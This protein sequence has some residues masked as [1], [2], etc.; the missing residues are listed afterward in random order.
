MTVFSTPIFTP[1]I[2][3]I[4]LLFAKL[5]GWKV[6]DS[7]PELEKAVLIG[8]PHTSNWDFFVM[9]MGALIMRLEVNWIGKHTLFVGPMGPIMRWLGGT[10]IDRSASKNFVDSVVEQFNTHKKLMV[11]IAPEGTRSPVPKWRSGFYFMAHL[12]EVPIVMSYVDYQKKIV[13]IYEVF[14]TTGD[15][16]QDIAY[17]QSVYAKIPGRHTHNYHGYDGPK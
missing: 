5:F 2:R 3:F 8:A 7:R 16:E 10:G 4:A 11:V 17:M 1:C 15:A 14:Q 12:A 13:G 6:P 9:L